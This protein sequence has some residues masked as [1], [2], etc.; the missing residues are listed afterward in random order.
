MIEQFMKYWLP[1]NSAALKSSAREALVVTLQNIR[2]EHY[3]KSTEWKLSVRHD[4]RY[5][6]TWI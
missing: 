2:A 1:R 3:M 6:K 4:Q 5:V